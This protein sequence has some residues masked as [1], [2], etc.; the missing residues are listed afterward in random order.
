MEPTIYTPD[1]QMF[2]DA[3]RKFVDRE[4]RPNSERWAEAG[5]VDR[6]AWR[7]AGTAGFL[8]PWLPEEYG[9]VGADFAYSCIIMEELARAYESGFAIPL[10]SDVVVPYLHT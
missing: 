2:R 6:E 7:K 4:V 5:M 8:C 9:G 10:H 1:H 3:F